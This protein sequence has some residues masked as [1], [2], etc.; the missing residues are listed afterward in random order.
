MDDSDTSGKDWSST[1][2][3]LVTNYIVDL[4][5]STNLE[6]DA[7]TTVKL[8]QT[9]SENSKK[10]IFGYL[11]Y[12]F[13]E[14]KSLLNRLSKYQTSH[15][16]Y[17]DKLGV[18]LGHLVRNPL[19]TEE[20]FYMNTEG[21]E[22]EHK[23]ISNRIRKRV[24]YK[25]YTS[26]QFSSKN[27]RGFIQK[28]PVPRQHENRHSANINLSLKTYQPAGNGNQ[29]NPSPIQ[30]AEENCQ[31]NFSVRWECR[32]ERGPEERSGRKKTEAEEGKMSFYSY[33]RFCL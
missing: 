14:I 33:F 16:R 8:A 15:L 29:G 10:R 19:G 5:L 2:E 31:P 21:S 24:R 32:A 22:I 23:T 11:K 17:F 20:N 9:S 26:F 3:H 12:K 28:V 6:T 25:K 1:K 30:D 27:L 13:K 18:E 7:V 4:G